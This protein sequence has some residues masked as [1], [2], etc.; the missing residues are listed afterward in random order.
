MRERGREAPRRKVGLGGW[1]VRWA[2]SRGEWPGSSKTFLEGREGGGRV[3]V[4]RLV[5][6]GARLEREEGGRRSR[7]EGEGDGGGCS[8]VSVGEVDCGAGF[9]RRGCVEEG[10]D[11]ESVGGG[12][13]GG[14]GIRVF[15]L[16]TVVRG[17][18]G[19]R[20]ALAEGRTAAGGGGGGIDK[21]GCGGAPDGGR[22]G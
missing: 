14:G 5:G 4:E 6:V 11:R 22:E 7:V 13:G 8:R 21:S 20:F 9:R 16:E 17:L 19:F 1:L 2:Q 3:D 15:G 18:E 12:G 10:R